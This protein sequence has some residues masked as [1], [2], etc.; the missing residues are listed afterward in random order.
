MFIQFQFSGSIAPDECIT[1]K[2][3][4]VTSDMVKKFKKIS[5]SAGRP[6]SEIPSYHDKD[7]CL[8]QYENALDI[9][10]GNRPLP[11]DHI[12][13]WIP[14]T[15]QKYPVNAIIHYGHELL[16]KQPSFYESPYSEQ[17]WNLRG[18]KDE[19]F[20]YRVNLKGLWENGANDKVAYT[21][22]DMADF[23]R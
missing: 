10:T 3:V 14:E 1:S 17:I 11:S 22:D 2:F 5:K 6:N 12:G 19:W 13:L 18:V 9:Y 8:K 20:D 16:Q 4:I 7:Y 21:T 15:I 23:Q